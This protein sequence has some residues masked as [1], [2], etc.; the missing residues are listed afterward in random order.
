VA[1]EERWIAVEDAGRMRDALG[2][3]LPVG[4]PEAFTEPVRDPLGDLVARYA[5]THGPFHAGDCAARLG[6]GPAVVADVLHRLAASGRVVC[7]EFRPG[8][9]GQEW[10]DAEVLRTLRRRSVA[11][12]R[13]E[14]EP[15]PTAALG[16]FLPAWQQVRP[17][18]GRGVDALLR[19]VE[20]LAGA[21][22]PASALESLVLPARIDGY[23]PAMLDELT[24]AGEVLWAGAGALPGRDGWVCL[25][26]ADT[27][28]LLLP[29]AE[30][31]DP[32]PLH[33]A[34]LGALDGG[35][36]LF[37]R[38][39]SDRVFAGGGLGH[40]DDGALGEALWDLVWAGLVTNDTLAP[41]RAHL[42]TRAAGHRG[43]APVRA[44]LGGYT[45]PRHA[46]PAMPSRSGPP[47]LAGRWSLLPERAADPTRQAHALAE[48]LLDRHGVVTRDVVAAERVPGGFATVY[49][50]L[51]ALEDAGRARRGYFVE[52]LGGAQF[53]APG[54]VDRLRGFARD[55]AGEEEPVAVVLAATDPANPYGAALPWPERPA[56]DE[57]GAAAGG[58]RTDQPGPG[59]RP[60]RKAGALVVLVDGDPVLYVERGG[61]SVLSFG[62]DPARLDAAAGALAVA[63]RDG[64]LGRLAVQRAD[65]VTVHASPLA[66]ALERAGFRHTPKGLRLG[67]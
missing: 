5:R 54:A 45:R 24:S 52:S 48:V 56:P 17:R 38:A 22:V 27:A 44:R 20:Q 57:E 30:E 51:R 6:V 47:S 25:A 33:Q 26:P 59:H 42:G 49:P 31:F 64:A 53:A 15:V 16:R 67:V 3:A 41:L 61:R 32:G 29:P 60:G 58:P 43:A 19:V 4:V 46:R 1:G 11:R 65:G 8:G 28:E 63:V 12:L 34:V 21:V 13:Q 7:G 14:V 35:Q 9:S 18:A 10:C 2:V 37:F 50:V 39:L 36:A 23:T 40:P 55:G 66:G 62:D